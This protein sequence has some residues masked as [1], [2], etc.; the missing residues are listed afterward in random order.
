MG[1][2]ELDELVGFGIGQLGDA[3]A[4]IGY[5]FDHALAHQIKHGF[6]HWGG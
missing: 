4:G 1:R 6:A 5:D 3:E 2:Q